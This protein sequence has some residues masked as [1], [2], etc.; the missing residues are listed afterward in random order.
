MDINTNRIIILHGWGGHPE[1][2]WFPWLTKELE[3]EGW[4]VQIPQLPNTDKPN[5]EEW[6]KV[7]KS[8]NPDEQTI[9]VGHSLSN[10]L[11]LK[12]LESNKLKHVFLVAAWDW[13]FEEVKEFHETFFQDEFNYSKIIESGT[14]ITII[15]STND[16]WIDFERGKKLASKVKASFMPVSNA[17][18]FMKR[19]GYTKFPLLLEMIMKQPRD[20]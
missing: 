2:E 3:M 9:V 10:A 16:K 15:N 11:I 19:D 14:K 17:G 8:L 20:S 4:N 7:F 5:K 18:H 13:L 1:D 12:Y 6:M